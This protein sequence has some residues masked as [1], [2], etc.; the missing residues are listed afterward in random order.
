MATTSLTAQAVAELVGGRLLGNGSVMIRSV[1]PLD[2]A[3]PA[4]LSL[5]TGRAYSEDLLHSNAAA[6]L[7]TE[8]LSA[9]AAARTTCIIV[10]DPAR[11]MSEVVRH[12][13]PVPVVLPGIHPSAQLG[14]GVVLGRDV[15]LGAF[16]VLHAGVR[17]GAGCA[18]ASGSVLHD[19]VVLG[20]GCRLAE[21]VIC[22]PGVRLGARVIDQ[23]EYGARWCRIRLSHRCLG[24]P[25]HSPH[26]RRG[27][28]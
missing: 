26:W 25:A 14:R 9:E 20:D 8:R 3:G 7:V 15:S 23:G 10:D 28:R 21:N 1:A 16:V 27:S 13:M 5:F 18:V 2:R 6:V 22:G 12:F 17:L 24:A 11:A 19:D 4:D